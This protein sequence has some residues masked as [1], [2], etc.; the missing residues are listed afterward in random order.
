MEL[1]D[2]WNLP[3]EEL[4]LHSYQ[5]LYIPVWIENEGQFLQLIFS[6]YNCLEHWCLQV[7]LLFSNKFWSFISMTSETYQMRSSIYTL[8]KLS[9][10]LI[11]STAI[12]NHITKG[13]NFI[14]TYFL[15]CIVILYDSMTWHIVC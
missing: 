14:H 2:F 4:N 1:Y 3:D 7:N 9:T 6:W 12:C 8:I 5:A 13:N 15:P 10:S 11:S